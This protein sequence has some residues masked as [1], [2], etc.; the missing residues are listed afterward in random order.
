MKPSRYRRILLKIS[1]EMLAGDQGYGIQPKVL[2]TLSS[3]IADVVAMEVEVAIVIGE[4]TYF[5]VWLRVL[6]GWSGH[7]LI[8]WVCWQPC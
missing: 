7:R 1:G 5:A 2:E 6:L 8:I 3:E 4:E